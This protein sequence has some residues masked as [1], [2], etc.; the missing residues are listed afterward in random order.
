MPSGAAQRRGDHCL[1]Q[2]PV[3]RWGR[4]Q[5]QHRQGITARHLAEHGQCGGVELPQR[6]TQS[7][8]LPLPR[9]DQI[10]MRPGQGF[11]CLGQ[12][13]VAGDRAVVLPIGTHQVGQ[14]LR[15]PGIAFR[16]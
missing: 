10:L 3:T 8:G 6:R 2:C 4:G 7:T 12:L 1:G 16:P 5:F 9:P 11:H 15:F 14:D 13:A